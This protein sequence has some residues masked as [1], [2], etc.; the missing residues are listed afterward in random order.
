MRDYEMKLINDI[1]VLIENEF[2]RLKDGKSTYKDLKKEIDQEIS[3]IVFSGKKEY[4][5]L[6]KKV[7]YGLL[8]KEISGLPLEPTK[9]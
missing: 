3:K 6:I 2:I 5:A 4:G 1:T 7:M 9:R 8:E